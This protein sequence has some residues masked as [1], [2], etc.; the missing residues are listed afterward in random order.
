MLGR[1]QQPI[2]TMYWKSAICA[3]KMQPVTSS[4]QVG[5]KQDI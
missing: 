3:A 4:Q 2:R 1:T 5:F